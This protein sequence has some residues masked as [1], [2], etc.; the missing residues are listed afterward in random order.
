MNQTYKIEDNNRL[1]GLEGSWEHS[2]L[3][4]KAVVDFLKDEAKRLFNN[5]KNIN[6]R[7]MS[8]RE[9]VLNITKKQFMTI[10]NEQSK[11]HDDGFL[12]HG[13]DDN[14]SGSY[15]GLTRDLEC[16]KKTTIMIEI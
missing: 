1:L 7:L 5:P 3:T 14:N 9:Q 2:K 11:N 16:K 6:Y 15:V 10:V 12:H 8:S 13:Y 4:K